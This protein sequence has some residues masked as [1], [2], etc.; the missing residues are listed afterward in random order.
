MMRAADRSDPRVL[1]VDDSACYRQVI[2]ELLARRG[3]EIAG[4]AESIAAAL[5][6]AGT[7]QPDAALVDVRL[8]DGNGFELAARLTR[9][10]PQIAVLMTSSQF[11]HNFHARAGASGALGF[12]PKSRLAQIEFEAFWPRDG[13]G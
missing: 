11:D 4:E 3:Y 1:I 5:R 10:Y 7:V 6:L 8:P 2:C 13:C 12:V 9:S